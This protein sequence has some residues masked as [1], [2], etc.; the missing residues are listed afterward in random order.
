MRKEK[1]VGVYKE[2][3]GGRS[4]INM[5]SPWVLLCIKLMLLFL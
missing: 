1:N 3:V 4:G 5:F 2:E